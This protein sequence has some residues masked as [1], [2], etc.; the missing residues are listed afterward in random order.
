MKSSPWP[1]YSRSIP[2]LFFERSGKWADHVVFR[3]KKEGR[4]LDL[5][6]REVEEKV[7]AVA[8]GM[9]AMGIAARTRVAI[10][11][12]NRPE[13]AI[14]DLGTLA[15]DIINVPIYP[16]NTAEQVAFI[17]QDSGAECVVVENQKQL[18]KVL[19]VRDRLP[20]LRKLIVIEPHAADGDLVTD[21]DAVWQLGREKMDR[22]AIDR[23]LKA[24]DP[25]EV[26]TLIYTSGTT[27]NPKGVMLCHR[28]L[29]SNVY[30]VQEFLTMNPG[31]T[32]LQFLPMCHAFGRMEVYVFMMHRGTINFAESVEKIPDNLREIRPLIFVTVPRLLEKIHEKIIK[33]LETAPKAK[34]KLFHWAMAVGKQ[35]TKNKV[36]K[37]ASPLSLRLQFKIAEALVF[38]KVKEALGGRIRVLGYAAAPL[39][40]EIQYFFA[41]MGI[42]CLEAYGLTE[43]SPGL[44][45]NSMND[46]RLGSVG[47]PVADTEVR[48]AADGEILV[49]GPQ[50]MLGY[51]NNP[52]ATAEA[53]ENGWFHTGDIGKIDEDGYLYITDRKKDLII[54]AGGK[55]IA[56]QNI[57]NLLKLDLA[58][59]QVAV[60]GDRRNYLVALIVPNREWL[61]EFGRA[62]N[63]PGAP[64]AYLHHPEVRA[65]FQRR[66]DAANAKLAKYETI[67]KFELLFEPFTVE[68]NLLTPTMKVKRKNVMSA[69]DQLIDSLYSSGDR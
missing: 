17:L 39:A 62:K 32:D 58:I 30:A 10:L 37:K 54:T 27:G 46:F 9:L 50:V 15:V 25:E 8:S 6:W 22:A 4:W 47:K 53:L 29:T 40:L 64:I 45:G 42:F 63:L 23:R 5:T 36:E 48:I 24:I 52:A 69:Y 68:N 16:T 51:W 61:T 7:L 33:G 49:H 38:S 44:T 1:K 14:V 19:S 59:E 28:N 11:S 41:A 57:E 13:W 34:A 60:I 55:N 67:K 65:E 21:L 43:T 3:H 66:I 35:I 2:E 56:P 20:A 26:A 31:D 12:Q 18:E